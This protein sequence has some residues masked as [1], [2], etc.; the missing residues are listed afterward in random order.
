MNDVFGGLSK[1]KVIIIRVPIGEDI[2]IDRV[3]IKK[4]R[5]KRLCSISRLILM[6]YSN[7]YILVRVF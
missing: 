4:E 2:G 3:Y 5:L 1:I 6:S 7:L